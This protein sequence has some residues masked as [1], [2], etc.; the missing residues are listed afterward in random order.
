M[1]KKWAQLYCTLIVL[2]L[3]VF[4][5]GPAAS[6]EDPLLIP[7]YSLLLGQS[8]SSIRLVKDIYPGVDDSDPEELVVVNGLLYFGATDG[9]HGNEI[10]TSDGTAEGTKMLKDI[11]AG[12][13]DSNSYTTTFTVG[14][15]RDITPMNGFLYFA[16]TDGNH[17]VTLWKS[18]GTADGT[19]EVY[20]VTPGNF[21]VFN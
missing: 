7:M 3:F 12:A 15:D 5:P 9:V 4:I 11:N 1:K 18:D 2:I 16:A 10:W 6:A 20:S 14:W 13:G 21:I 17:P 8:G 19:S